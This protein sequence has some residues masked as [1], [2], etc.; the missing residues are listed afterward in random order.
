MWHCETAMLS[1]NAF[2]PCV[3]Q[4]AVYIL[5]PGATYKEPRQVQ[6]LQ[7]L[8]MWHCAF[9]C[10]WALCATTRNCIDPISLCN[11]QGA[12]ASTAL[13]AIAHVAL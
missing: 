11:L 12:K 1:A 10:L 2:A 3:A 8:L 4:G 6:P 13:I 5:F 7:L 9:K